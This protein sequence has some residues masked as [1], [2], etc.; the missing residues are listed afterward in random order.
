MEQ[1][2]AGII[3]EPRTQ[4]A[5]TARTMHAAEPTRRHNMYT[6]PH[7]ALRLW[8]CDTLAAAG[9]AD[10]HDDADV[11]ALTGKVRALLKFC[12]AHLE[13]EDHFVHPA[14]EA[15]RPGSAATTRAD[16]HEHV[17]AFARL[18][19]GLRDIETAPRA[20]RGSAL[21][22]L[23]RQLALFTADNLAHMDI[24]ETDNNAV[25]W[26][27]YSDDELLALEERLV[28]SIPQEMKQMAVPW[29]VRAMNPAER[30]AFLLA[31]GATV[32]TPVF[33]GMLAGVQ[34]LLTEAERNKLARALAN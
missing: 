13:K 23:Y 26:A 16:H 34:T 18:E 24:E 15:R 7:K 4:H 17:E 25:L 5:A 6:V 20:S 29:M 9:R 28:A 33:Q 10:P 30:A 3:V 8:L 19:S 12:R 22:R 1:S 21:D 27:I 31:V 11:A 2:L 32:P 14:M